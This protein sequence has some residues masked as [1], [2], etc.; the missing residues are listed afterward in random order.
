MSKEF[1]IMQMEQRIQLLL[2]R[3]ETMN[4]R[5]INKLKRRI[6]KLKGE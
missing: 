6:R 5:L 2:S 1:R 4:L 3:G